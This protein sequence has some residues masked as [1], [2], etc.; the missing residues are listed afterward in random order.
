MRAAVLTKVSPAGSQR[1]LADASAIVGQDAE[2]K[3]PAYDRLEVAPE[4]GF[5]DR[6]VAA[7]SEQRRQPLER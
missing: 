6:L 5:A 2:A 4:R 7:L 1:L 3:K